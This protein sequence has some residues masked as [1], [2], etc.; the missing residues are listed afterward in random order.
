MRRTMEVLGVCAL[1]AMF[2]GN[3]FADP[4]ETSP[5]AGAATEE[6][7]AAQIAEEIRQ[8]LHQ[9]I[10]LELH[11]VA[12]RDA[13]EELLG[14]QKIDFFFD[15]AAIKDAEIAFDEVE[16]SC[17]LHNVSVRAA[18]KRVL[19]PAKL[20]W[21]CDDAGVRIT[22]LD[23]AMSTTFPRVY[24]VADLLE[25]PTVEVNQ[26]QRTLQQAQFGGGGP[27]TAPEEKAVK[28]AKAAKD[29][30]TPEKILIKMIQEATG[31]VP[32]APWM[33]TDGEG[34]T[35]H[36]IQ[37]THSKLLVVRQ[38]EQVQAEI[39]DLL[40]ELIS[41]HHDIGEEEMEVTV[42]KNAV[43]GQLRLPTQNVVKKVPR[44]LPTY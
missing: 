24:D 16:V 15:D 29:A 31:G 21:I 17:K 40:N 44:K 41:H 2:L 9:P 27:V 37:T 4:P 3:V 22:S 35:V 33:E 12:I 7:S 5:P 10:T 26:P 32:N 20:S 6:H 19:S 13:I 38:N 8:R 28:D 23:A 43:R 42:P 11:D 30:A 34:G 36:F 25:S 39:E 14:K 1:T 18:L